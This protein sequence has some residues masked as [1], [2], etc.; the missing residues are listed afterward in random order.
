MFY[1]KKLSPLLALILI[2]LAIN[3]YQTQQAEKTA[4]VTGQKGLITAK[5]WLVKS[6][7]GGKNESRYFEIRDSL[8]ESANLS[9]NLL[10]NYLKDHEESPNDYHTFSSTVKKYVDSL[11]ADSIFL[12]LLI[13]SEAG[14][15]DEAS[16]DSLVIP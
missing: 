13:T 5:L 7:Y 14:P 6:V 9:L 12:K 3:W 2:V 16:E 15:S 10:D 4:I 8:L 1:F 11:S